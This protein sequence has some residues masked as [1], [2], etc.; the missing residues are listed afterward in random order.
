MR[1]GLSENTGRGHYDVVFALF[2]MRVIKLQTLEHAGRETLEHN[3]GPIDQAQNKIA[4]ARFLEV[5]SDAAL[6]GV[7]VVIRDRT[8]GPALP[9]LE[10]SEGSQRIDS[11]AALDF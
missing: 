9:V 3:I 11:A 7:Q 1:P 2:Q 10:R 4:S 6:S 5:D 8:L